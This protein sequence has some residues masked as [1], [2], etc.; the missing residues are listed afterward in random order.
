MTGRFLIVALM[1]SLAQGL[2]PRGGSGAIAQTAAPA[3]A[4]PAVITP[5]VRRLTAG[6][7][8]VIP[9]K[10]EEQETFSGP[11]ELVELVYT[12]P[13]LTWTPNFT[14]QSQTLIEIAK[15]VTFRREVWQLEFGFKPLR[16]ITVDVPQPGGKLERKVIWY[17]YYY[18]QN[19]GGH[20]SPAPE[21][22]EF[23]HQTF[24]TNPINRPIR[25]FP[26]FML[27]S[28]DQKKAYLDRVIPVAAARIQQREDPQ[29]RLL[30]SVE[31]SQVAVPVSS[32]ENRQR[33]WGVATWEDV[34]PRTDYFSIYIQGLS[35][36]YLWQ[37]PPGAFKAGDPPGTGRRYASKTLQ[38]NFW[39]PGDEVLEHEGE[40]RYGMPELHDPTRAAELLTLYGVPSR[41]DYLWI[42]R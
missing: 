40:V 11:R 18:V 36:A 31:I 17:L 1:L 19:N 27:V 9:P 26:S 30:N 35:N 12:A 33:L 15:A 37:D 4:P 5:G 24:T 7:L 25:F 29:V 41:V 28:H 38:M 22:D 3:P 14:P 10:V 39:R 6:V 34:D 8:T 20:M 21:K 13:P 2:V 23:G 42:Y 16:M 32:P